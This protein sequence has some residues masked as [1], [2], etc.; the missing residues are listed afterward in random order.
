MR[1]NSG[2]RKLNTASSD[3]KP[4]PYT[5]AFY[6]DCHI[7]S[8]LSA[9]TV[10]PIVCG[11]IS[12]ASAV[13]VG[14]ARGEWLTAFRENGVGTVRGLDGGYVDQSTLLIEREFFTPSDLSGDFQ[15]P[16]K[17]DLAI[18]LEV[19][20]H[21]PKERAAALVR[22][23]TAAAPV[24]LFSAAV[25]GQGGTD[26]VNERWPG[27]WRRLFGEQGYTMLDPVRPLI[28]EDR[29]VRWWYRQN[30]VM[31][32]SSAAIR[33]N[34][35]LAAEAARPLQEMEWVHQHLMRNRGTWRFMLTY[36]RRQLKRAFRSKLRR[37][38]KFA[39]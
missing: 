23:L 9:R 12:P 6:D 31:F 28:R 37:F 8:L 2:I 27:Y 36:L 38:R 18:C 3:P 33:D 16:G 19:A 24:I 35:S 29:R 21:L 10:A 34:P 20:E 22:R 39:H 25:P 4:T 13:D 5:G 17:F 11:L 32:A 26:H 1:P 7:G 30:I 14:C 15:I